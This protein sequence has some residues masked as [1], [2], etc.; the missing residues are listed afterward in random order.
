[1]SNTSLK[2]V[3]ISIPKATLEKIDTLTDRGDRSKFIDQAVHFYVE[4]VGRK[5]LRESLKDGALR[6]TTRDI[7]IATQWFPIDESVWKNRQ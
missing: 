3:N 6:H 2:R 7:D 5:Q 1:M 4:A